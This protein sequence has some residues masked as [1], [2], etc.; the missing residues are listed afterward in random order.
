MLDTG[1]DNGSGFGSFFQRLQS[2]LLP[3]G[4]NSYLQRECKRGFVD[5]RPI[6]AV[7]RGPLPDKSRV[8]RAIMSFIEVN[9]VVFV[10]SYEALL[11][12][13]ERLYSPNAKVNHSNIATVLALIALTESADQEYH[14]ACQYLEP[15]LAE[16]TLDSVQAI[17]LLVRPCTN[18]GFFFSFPLLNRI[19][20][21]LP[22]EQV[23]AECRM[24]LARMRRADRQ[25]PRAPHR[26]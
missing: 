11:G 8:E 6:D 22:A 26:H 18:L 20:G 14:D 12:T 9:C 3:P 17:I 4:A 21:P 15:V 10:A 1:F 23:G 25:V 7:I 19:P 2:L 13:V 24:G 5:G 16:S